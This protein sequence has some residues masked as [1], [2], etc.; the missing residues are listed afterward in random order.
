M[1]NMNDYQ[2]E[3]MENSQIKKAG[4]AKKAAILAAGGLGLTAT[5]AFAADRLGD[6]QDADTEDVLTED[7]LINGAEAASLE[8]PAAP[9]PAPAP[10]ETTSAPAPEPV[11]EPEVEVGE[12]G[13]AFDE[14]GNLIAQ[15]DAGTV[16][17]DA[18][19]VMDTD[20]NGKGDLIAIDLNS[21]GNIESNEI[22]VLDNETYSMGNPTNVV[23]ID[24]NEGVYPDPHPMPQEIADIDDIHNDFF[25]ETTGEEYRQDLADNNPDYNNRGDV[26]YYAAN[27]QDTQ[28]PFD[29]D[30][31]YDPM[32]QY[33][34]GCEYD[35][36]ASTDTFDDP[37]ADDAF[38]C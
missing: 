34:N 33:D 10:V 20:F 29:P 13:I 8:E 4:T 25:D 24:S 11:H 12:S 36:L 31:P 30:A 22:A 23:F 28:D 15:Y 38:I 17:G 6:M 37:A 9:A 21:N 18:Y 16:D 26:D 19:V 32:A 27:E 35:D 1:S 5:G 2:L 3:E 7:D 14:D